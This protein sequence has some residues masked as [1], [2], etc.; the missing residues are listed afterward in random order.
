VG[1]NDHKEVRD[2]A[3]VFLLASQQS[4]GSW[5]TEPK[6]ISGATTPEQLATRAEIYHYWGT[7]WA[8]LGLLST[9]AE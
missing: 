6:Y 9:L 1:A 8:V 7:S 2:K 4:D 3:I 5:K